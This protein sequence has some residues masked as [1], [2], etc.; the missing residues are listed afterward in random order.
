VNAARQ[1]GISPDAAQKFYSKIL[2]IKD[3]K[4]SVTGFSTGLDRLPTLVKASKRARENK[5]TLFYIEVDLRNLGGL[6][7]VLKSHSEANKL[8]KAM[9]D[10]V[11]NALLPIANSPEELCAFRHGGDEF[12]FVIKLK[13]SEIEM[14]AQVKNSLQKIETINQALSKAQE[15]IAT[16]V[17]AWPTAGGT[18]DLSTISHPKNC[19]SEDLTTKFSFTPEQIMIADKLC[20]PFKGTGIYFGISEILPLPESQLPKEMAECWLGEKV[21]NVADKAMSLQKHAEKTKTRKETRNGNSSSN[22]PVDEADIRSGASKALN[23]LLEIDTDSLLRS[24]PCLAL[25]ELSSIPQSKGS[26]EQ[27]P[28]GN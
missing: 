5:E 2:E 14:Q 7:S 4:D 10:V 9:A 23:P 25:G 28:A 27:R 24:S 3:P 17:K 22:M 20:E 21:I 19:L 26:T 16:M 13:N 18:K 8:F 12:S 1:F 6:N 15:D 11:K